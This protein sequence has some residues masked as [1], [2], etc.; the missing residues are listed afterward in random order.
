[1][2]FYYV[3]IISVLSTLT[4]LAQVSKIY[5]NS[6]GEFTADSKKAVSY[7]LIE[8]ASD[9]AYITR[10]YNLKDTLTQQGVYKDSLLTIPNGK[11]TYYTKKKIPDQLKGVLLTD[12]NNFISMVGY[13]SNGLKTGLWFEFEK[14]GVKKS[15][16]F[17]K[18]DMLN[19]LYQRYHKSIENYVIEDGNYVNNKREGSW[20]EYGYDTLNTAVK[21]R[22]YQ[23]DN[24]IKEITHVKAPNFPRD[25]RVYLLKKFKV[26]DTVSLHSV[27]T[28]ITIES[29]GTIKD[30][31]VISS[32][33][34]PESKMIKEILEGMPKFI[35]ETR[36]GKPVDSTYSFVFSSIVSSDE[37]S[38]NLLTILNKDIHYK[39][40]FGQ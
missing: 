28:V 4:T 31:R 34:P 6:K 36:D 19:G 32:L 17:F 30:V 11:F 27:N 33:P 18:N 10:N 26:L 37:S 23:N 20:K 13:F 40:R 7:V 9:S 25:L 38:R 35:P 12:T 22:I 2:K 15:S 1:M 3:L 24:L 8:K 39:L 29:D 21:E 14:R 5:V 16:Y